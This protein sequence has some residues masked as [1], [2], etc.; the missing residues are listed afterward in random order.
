MKHNLTFL[1]GCPFVDY[2]EGL[3]FIDSGMLISI[4]DKGAIGFDGV[5]E[6]V[7]QEYGPVN[8]SVLSDWFE[9]PVAGVIGGNLLMRNPIMIDYQA[10]LMITHYDGP[11]GTMIGKTMTGY[12]MVELSIDG[13]RCQCFIDT[14]AQY[15]YLLPSLTE[16]KESRERVED[17]KWGAPGNRFQA[18]LYDTVFACNGVEYEVGCGALSPEDA[19][20]VNRAGVSGVIGKDFFDHHTIVIK[21]GA[22]YAGK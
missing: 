21:N 22:V 9:Q 10:G 19:N 18:D 14:G 4:A 13:S 2:G 1:K 17:C 20:M 5:T 11:V 8:T 6:R 12:P 7:P 3:M 16:G 15:S